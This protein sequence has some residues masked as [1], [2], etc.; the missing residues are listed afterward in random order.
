MLCVCDVYYMCYD[1]IMELVAVQLIQQTQN[2]LYLGL[3]FLG[4]RAVII[5]LNLESSNGF[6][7]VL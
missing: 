7:N 5:M 1:D 2:E 3:H 4:H 6:D